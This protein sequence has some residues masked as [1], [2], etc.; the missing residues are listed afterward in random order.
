MV[1]NEEKNMHKELIKFVSRNTT[2]HNHQIKI[3]PQFSSGH[4]LEFHSRILEMESCLV[5][6]HKEGQSQRKAESQ[7]APR[8]LSEFCHSLLFPH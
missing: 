6:C 7:A 8:S 2:I 5:F 4:C 3:Y 1:V